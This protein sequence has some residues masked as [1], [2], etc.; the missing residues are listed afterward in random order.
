MLYE[1]YLVK[2]ARIVAYVC[3]LMGSSKLHLP[4]PALNKPR[5]LACTVYL[6]LRASDVPPLA[7]PVMVTTLFNSPRGRK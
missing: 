7:L 3:M 2:L 5:C 4:P 1:G 6:P